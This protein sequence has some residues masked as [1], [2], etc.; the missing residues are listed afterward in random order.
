[1]SNATQ[2]SVLSARPSLYR[3][4]CMLPVPFHVTTTA[5]KSPGYSYR[6]RLLSHFLSIDYVYQVLAQ[7][8]RIP[9]PYSYLWLNIQPFKYLQSCVGCWCRMY[10]LV[11]GRHLLPS[12]APKFKRHRGMLMFC[13]GSWQMSRTFADSQAV[14]TSSAYKEKATQ[15]LLILSLPVDTSDTSA[16]SR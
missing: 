12:Q 5:N 13:L 14:S 4:N 11:F 1:M 8:E 10:D 16:T 15:S 6:T 9:L 3:Y 2:T 7:F